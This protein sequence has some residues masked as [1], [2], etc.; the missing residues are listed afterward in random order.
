MWH[1]YIQKKNS[2]PE[3]CLSFDVHFDYNS[4]LCLFFMMC[5]AVDDM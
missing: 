1:N 3:V 4:K 5:D 2:K